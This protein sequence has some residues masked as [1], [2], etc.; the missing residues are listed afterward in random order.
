MGLSVGVWLSI[1]PI[2]F[3]FHQASNVFS[4][5][6]CIRLGLSHPSQSLGCHIAF[7]ANFWT[8]WGFTFFLA[9]MWGKDDLAW[10]WVRC[11]HGHCKRCEISNIARTTHVLSPPT[12]QFSYCQV[13]IMLLVNGVYTLVNIGI[14]TP[15]KL[16]WFHKLFFLVGLL[17]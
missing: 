12:L 3:F 13:D 5:M 9:F 15:I 10:C 17:R 16:I 1:C 4:T 11:F 14:M 6:L 8:L 7:V 2:F